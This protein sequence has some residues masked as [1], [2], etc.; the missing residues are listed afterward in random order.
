MLKRLVWF[1][2]TDRLG[3]DI[4]STYFLL[5]FKKSASW[6]CRKKFGKFGEGAEFRP[7]AI[8][9][10]TKKIM[11]GK[12]VVIRPGSQLYAYPTTDEGKIIIE[13]DALIGPGV[14]FFANNHQYKNPEKKIVEQ[15]F[16][17]I[18]TIRVENG[19]WIGGCSIILSGVTIGEHAVVGAGSVVTKD[20]E[21]YSVVV[22]VPARKIKDIEN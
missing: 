16:S 18:A 2:K 15:G 3:P 17:D 20:V 14:H 22:G 5:F 6:L 4:P 9:V 7:G 19:A 21:A 12:N 1:W 10:S 13:D 8:A 11:L